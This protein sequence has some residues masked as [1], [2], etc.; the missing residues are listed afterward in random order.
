MCQKFNDEAGF[1]HFN[2]PPLRTECYSVKVYIVENALRFRMRLQF[3][4]TESRSRPSSLPSL[5][6][7]CS[8]DKFLFSVLSDQDEMEL[9]SEHL[10]VTTNLKLF[11]RNVD[12]IR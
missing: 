9:S 7:Q 11:F 4:F 6:A 2:S 1:L 3:H 10:T 8:L 12:L 5:T